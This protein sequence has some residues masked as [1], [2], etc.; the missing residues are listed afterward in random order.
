M[1][2]EFHLISGKSS[3]CG[4][5]GVR[6]TVANMDIFSRAVAEMELLTKTH[7]LDRSDGTLA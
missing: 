3:Q 1:S 5:A 7:S 4:K 2:D 6:L